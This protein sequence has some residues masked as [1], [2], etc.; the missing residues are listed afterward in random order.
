MQGA[1]ENFLHQKMPD[2]DLIGVVEASNWFC[3]SDTLLQQINQQQ[4]YAIYPYLQYGFVKWHLLFASLAWPKINFPLKGLEVCLLFNQKRRMKS[5][6]VTNGVY[7]T[8]K[9]EKRANFICRVPFFQKS[10][11]Q[12]SVFQ[13]LRKSITACTAGIGQGT[14]LLLET[15]PMLKRILSPHLRSVAIQL[16]STREQ[17]DLK[18]T[19]EIMVDLGLTYTQ[20]KS[21]EGSYVYGME[22]DLEILAQFSVTN[23]HDCG[24]PGITLAYFGRQ[25]IAREIELEAIKR[26][27]PKVSRELDQTK[28]SSSSLSAKSTTNLMASTNLPNH[29][30]R[31]EPKKLDKI[32]SIKANQEMRFNIFPRFFAYSV[33]SII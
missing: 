25:L 24:T 5:H 31:L 16:L 4:N 19:V 28:T 30:Q 2:P 7:T 21:A 12:R 33:W 1:F 18:H 26:A 10:T 13:S 20:L 8:N 14:K 32:A 3:F 17:C 11:T 29:M 9:M 22:P 23:K 6:V 15:V 27:V